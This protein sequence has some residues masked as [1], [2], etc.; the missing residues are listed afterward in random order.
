MTRVDELVELMIILRVQTPGSSSWF[1]VVDA[2][3]RMLVRI[4][5]DRAAA[6]DDVNKR[7]GNSPSTGA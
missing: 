7:E 5:L 4:E 3:I 2:A 6:Q 1:Q